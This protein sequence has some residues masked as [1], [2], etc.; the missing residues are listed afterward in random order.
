MNKPIEIIGAAI[1]TLNGVFITGDLGIEKDIDIVA[2]MF[3]AVSSMVED[4]FKKP[5][6]QIR[7]GDL[8]VSR[9]L[10]STTVLWITSSGISKEFI[11]RS[12]EMIRD[13]ER[14][15]P[16]LIDWDGA[17]SEAL[18]LGFSD[19]ITELKRSTGPAEDF[20]VA[21]P[22]FDI[23]KR[24][25]AKEH[26]GELEEAFNG[27]FMLGKHDQAFDL[28][29]R[30]ALALEALDPSSKD[31]SL[32]FALA[33]RVI[34]ERRDEGASAQWLD[35]SQAKSAKQGNAIAQ[36]E[37]ACDWALYNVFKKKTKEA[38]QWAQQAKLLLGGHGDVRTDPRNYLRLIRFDILEARCY[39]TAG[40]FG[41]ALLQW[42]R[43]LG[44]IGQTPKGAS[45]MDGL[46]LLRE[47]MKIHNNIGYALI[48]RDHADPKNYREALPHYRKSLQKIQESNAKW[49]S[50]AGKANLAQAL[51]FTGEL[52]EARELL[53]SAIEEAREL[54]SEYN[55]A[56][57]EGAYGVYHYRL[58]LK[59]NELD[60]LYEAMHWFKTALGRQKDKLELDEVV[61]FKGETEKAIKKMM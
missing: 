14:H 40:D 16:E 61:F 34:I 6:D 60:E 31:S 50:P 27:Y 33:A 5:A 20:D 2:A 38:I 55:I 44:M 8:Y 51:C 47:E 7:L 24:T 29:N 43:I 54:R 32:F 11:A 59:E 17:I 49:Y 53:D 26:I 58:G 12:K 41:S 4:T 39:A 56:L 37:T 15:H 30:A 45:A 18:K 28:A 48:L 1:V 57:V 25:D 3:S 9:L 42:K 23:L 19:S 35:K 36:A 46:T 21:E 22:G 13:F 52:E 10:G